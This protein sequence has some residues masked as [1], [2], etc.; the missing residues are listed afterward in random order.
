[1]PENNI[2]TVS[3]KEKTVYL[4]PSINL[5]HHKSPS[6]H[7]K[8]LIDSE[9]LCPGQRYNQIPGIYHLSNK[10]SMVEQIKQYA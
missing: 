2:D 4:D 8:H 9:F 7:E 1:M 5:F 10:D 3:N 6:W